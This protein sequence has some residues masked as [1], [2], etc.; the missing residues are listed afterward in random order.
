MKPWTRRRHLVGG[1]DADVE[2]LVVAVLVGL[3]LGGDAGLDVLQRDGG[4][5]NDG[6]AAVAD[7][8]EDDGGIELGV[9]GQRA[10][11]PQRQTRRR[12]ASTGW[13]GSRAWRVSCA[14]AEAAS[15]IDRR[16]PAARPGPCQE[17]RRLNGGGALADDGRRR[18]E[19]AASCMRGA[20]NWRRTCDG[21]SV[22]AASR[23]RGTARGLGGC[24]C[25]L[26]T[27]DMSRRALSSERDV[28]VPDLVGE[29]LLEHPSRTRNVVRSAR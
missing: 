25:S 17:Q 16:H 13:S 8:A 20:T 24:P 28:L 1:A 29:A 2:E 14:A 9:E 27:C 11:D 23:S 5:G 19:L 12:S 21:A 4:A 6:A 15:C 26:E 18:Q 22:S 3:G 7:G 10:D